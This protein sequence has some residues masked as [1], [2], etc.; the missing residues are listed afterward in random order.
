MSATRSW[1]LGAAVLG[2]ALAVA[3]W[4]TLIAP[5]R[6]RAAALQAQV[7]AQEG[8][9]QQLLVELAVARD[10]A[11][12]LPHTQLLLAQ[13]QNYLPFSPQLPKLI[14]QLSAVSS[15][16]GVDLTTLA[17]ADP[18]PL[19]AAPG[20]TTGSVGALYSLPLSLSVS[21]GFF[22]VEN[23]IASLEQLP[24]ALVVTSVQLARGS[25]STGSAAAAGGGTSTSTASAGPVAGEVSASVSVRAFLTTARLQPTGSASG[26]GVR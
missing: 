21:G 22:Q 3:G 10:Q 2:L 18:A 14:R 9:Q 11:R 6:A 7:T 17:P 8:S 1:T 26:T 20:G 5:Q 12:N 4:F 13:A 24:R 23:F 15:A 19:T 25:G 16:D